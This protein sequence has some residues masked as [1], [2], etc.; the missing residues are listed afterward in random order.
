[1]NKKWQFKII[2]VF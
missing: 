2:F 1:M